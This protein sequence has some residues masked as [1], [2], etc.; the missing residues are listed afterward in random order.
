MP[1][2]KKDDI[3]KLR[4][5]LGFVDS[6]P[7]LD[8]DK[9]QHIGVIKYGIEPLERW[10]ACPALTNPEWIVRYVSWMAINGERPNG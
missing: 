6:N 2:Q 1:R 3:E 9:T 8:K 5:N 4:K 10:G 7:L